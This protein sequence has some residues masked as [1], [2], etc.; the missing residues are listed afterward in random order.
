MFFITIPNQHI[1]PSGDVGALNSVYQILDTK[2]FKT[3]FEK[4]KTTSVLVH[5]LDAIPFSNYHPVE[6]LSYEEMVKVDLKGRGW[7]KSE[8]AYD[9]LLANNAEL[10]KAIITLGGN[11]HGLPFYHKRVLADKTLA[12][13]TGI[14]GVDYE[15]ENGN[16][17]QK[18]WGEYNFASSGTGTKE[19]ETYFYMTLADGGNGAFDGVTVFTLTNGSDLLTRQEYNDAV[20]A[21]QI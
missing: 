7:K 19:D 16:T 21:E 14:P 13:P 4:D 17:L 2:G 18:T 8:E 15:D 9:H 10:F 11:V 20:P 12:M 5:S 1:R 3:L 6:N